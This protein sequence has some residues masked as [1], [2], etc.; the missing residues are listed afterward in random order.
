[1]VKISDKQCAEAGIVLGLLFVLS[2]LFT[3]TGPWYKIAAVI[4]LTDLAVPKVFRP[5]AWFWF[6][7]SHWLGFITSRVLLSAIFILIIIPV[8]L[9]R[10]LG[11]AD[12]LRL[13]EFKKSTSSVFTDRNIKFGAGNLNQ[14]Y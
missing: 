3:H 5:F 7:L 9:F 14:T 8:A 12:R 6:N 10:K 2:G 4:L 11:G 13:K 1:M